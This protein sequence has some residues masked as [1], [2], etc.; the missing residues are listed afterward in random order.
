MSGWWLVSYLV[1]WLLVAASFVVLLVVLRQLGLIYMRA[2]GGAVFLDEGPAVGS[3][4][5]TF[6]EPGLIS[7]QDVYFPDAH[8]AANL[9]IVA[10]PHCAICKDVLGGLRAVTKSRDLRAVVLSEGSAEENS[11]LAAVIG[12]RANLMANLQRQRMLGIQSIPYAILT[13]AEGIVLAKGPTNSLDELEDIIERSAQPVSGVQT[14]AVSPIR[15]EQ[16]TAS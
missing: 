16:W 9:L 2:K 6:G 3:R 4:V 10:S 8:S 13:S 12:D 5:T 15:E 7:G 14:A 11:E 1:L